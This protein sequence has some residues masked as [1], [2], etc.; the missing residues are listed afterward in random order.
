[1]MIRWPRRVRGSCNDWSSPDDCSPYLPQSSFPIVACVQHAC[2][3]HILF[4]TCSWCCSPLQP[5]ILLLWILDLVWNMIRRKVLQ[6]HLP[7]SRQKH[8]AWLQTK[9]CN[10]AFGDSPGS[11]KTCEQIWRSILVGLCTNSGLSYFLSQ[12]SWFQWIG[13][14]ENL[15]ETIDF[16]I[17]YGVFL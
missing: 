9:S 6:N 12:Q 17:K 3:M 13:L 1:M 11:F 10:A 15:Q 16:P 5:S 4:C 8:P 14:R 2:S 7:S